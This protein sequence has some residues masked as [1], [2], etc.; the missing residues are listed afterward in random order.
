MS[1]TLQV[2]AVALLAL[3]GQLVI[4]RYSK[5]ANDKTA[6]VQDRANTIDGTDRL[7]HNLE[8]RLDKVEKRADS[9]AGRVAQLEEERTRDRSLIRHLIDYVH[10]LR[11]AL[12]GANVP[13]PEAP[14]GLDLDGG[15][16]A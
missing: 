2:I 11:D 12:R 10:V 1:S 15:P 7:I 9:L 13:V 14:G 8:T 4:A 5:R 6:E 3:V 16:L